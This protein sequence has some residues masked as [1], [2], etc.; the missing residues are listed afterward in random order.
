MQGAKKG[1][2]AA[3]SAPIRMKE[4]PSLPPPSSL[5]S[6]GHRVKLYAKWGGGGGGGGGLEEFR[7]R[8]EFLEMCDARKKVF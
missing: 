1:H 8:F 6:R 7:G 5:L 2:A 3:A 4:T